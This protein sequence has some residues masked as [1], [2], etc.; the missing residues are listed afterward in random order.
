MYHIA[1]FV[2]ITWWQPHFTLEAVESKYLKSYIEWVKTAAKTI[3]YWEP[4]EIAWWLRRSQTQDMWQWTIEI[5]MQMV[6]KDIK[7][8]LNKTEY[9]KLT[10]DSDED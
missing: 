5:V 7:E 6:L 1:T 2:T 8:L 9:A 10:Q 3:W 4:E